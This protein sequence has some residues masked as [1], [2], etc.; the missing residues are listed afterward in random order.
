MADA[1]DLPRLV[2]YA[3]YR[4]V[5]AWRTYERLAERAQPGEAQAMLYQLV[6]F[7][8]DHV[9]SYTVKLRAQIEA[10]GLNP[11]EIVAAAEAE[12][13]NLEGVVDE[14]RIATAPLDGVIKAAIGF[15]RMMATF[16]AEEAEK[17]TDPEIK[18]VLLQLGEEEESHEVFLADL[19]NALAL[20]PADDPQE[21]PSL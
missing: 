7:E 21:F 15:E 19:L 18:A 13:L 12:P 9:R 11:D 17:V 8:E 3:L 16:Y 4:E 5:M 2:H 14:E 6:A 10:T 20:N 1:F